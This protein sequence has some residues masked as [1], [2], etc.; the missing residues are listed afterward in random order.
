LDFDAD[1]GAVVIWFSDDPSLNE[2]TRFRQ[3]EAR[4]RI[5]HSDMV[6]V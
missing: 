5:N 2:Q 4:D 6:V 1:P 3:M